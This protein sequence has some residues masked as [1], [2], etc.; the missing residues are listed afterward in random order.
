MSIALVFFEISSFLS[1][2]FFSF[3]AFSLVL[4]L[5]ERLDSPD[6]TFPVLDDLFFRSTETLSFSDD[7]LVCE[8]CLGTDFLRVV[9]VSLITDFDLDPVLVFFSKFFL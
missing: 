2:V 3:V 5:S 9:S 1:S 8:A 7:F 4:S 6:A